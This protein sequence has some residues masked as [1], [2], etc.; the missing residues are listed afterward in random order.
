MVHAVSHDSRH[1]H[2]TRLRGVD[3]LTV[4]RERDAAVLHQDGELVGRFAGA[5]SPFTT[6]SLATQ[7]PRSPVVTTAVE[8][9]MRR[10]TRN[11]PSWRTRKYVFSAGSCRRARGRP[12]TAHTLRDA[13][14]LVCVNVHDVVIAARHVLI[15]PENGGGSIV[16]W[17][18]SP[19]ATNFTSVSDGAACCE[20]R[21]R[22]AV[23][24]RGNPAAPATLLLG[25]PCLG[26]RVES[27]GR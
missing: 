22:A 6:A 14:G 25:R 8:S 3:R 10:F 16:A 7:P 18:P 2:I 15:A 20:R 24:T 1:V 21:R 27:L 26:R 13:L 5:L 4:H 11:L 23:P 19:I 17:K 12:G 9:P